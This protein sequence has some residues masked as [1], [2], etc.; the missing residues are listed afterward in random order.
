MWYAQYRSIQ[1]VLR[2]IVSLGSLNA[3]I[4][5]TYCS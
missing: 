5:F 2:D 4:D 3:N 1:L